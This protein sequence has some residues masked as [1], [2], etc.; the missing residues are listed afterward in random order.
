MRNYKKK[1]AILLTIF[2][3]FTAINIGFFFSNLNTLTPMVQTVFFNN[4]KTSALHNTTVRI[5]DANPA[6][7]WATAKAA[8]ICT[9]TGTSSNPYI[10]NN[11]IFNVTSGTECLYILNSRKY[12]RVLNC[13]FIISGFAG[14]IVLTNTTNGLIEDNQLP[15]SIFVNILVDNCSQITLRDNNCSA[16]GAGIA[17]SD[18]DNIIVDSNIVNDNFGIG[19]TLD[20][21]DD[22]VIEDNDVIRNTNQGVY[23]D[24]S[25]FVTIKSNTFINN[26]ISVEN[27]ISNN[28]KILSNTITNS[29][30]HGIRIFQSHRCEI[31][32]NTITLSSNDGIRVWNPFNNQF[33]V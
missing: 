7:N 3:S 2:L 15:R 24:N 17:L 19:I 9:G 22:V 12:F 33:R 30:N 11:D 14:G 23:F 4:P 6:E 16:S 21:C 20:N 1:N 25:E 5:D 31:S 26:S 13:E 10:I 32:G 18:S 29:G 27:Y 28:S 8:G